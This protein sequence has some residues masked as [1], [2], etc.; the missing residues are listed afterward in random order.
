MNSIINR[1]E[2]KINSIKN[3]N[4]NRR[5]SL[6]LDFN[7]KI[8]N[9][10]DVKEV[11]SIFKMNKTIQKYV[12]EKLRLLNGNIQ[13]NRTSK[14]LLRNINN[15]KTK[16]NYSFN[17][18]IRNK[19]INENKNKKIKGRNYR[20]DHPLFSN[21]FKT[22]YVNVNYRFN[23]STTKI[24]NK[25]KIKGKENLKK[26]INEKINILIKNP[27]N[28]L[29]TK[30]KL[31]NDFYQN[32]LS[33]MSMSTGISLNHNNEIIYKEG[34]KDIIKDNNTINSKNN[35]EIDSIEED[36]IHEIIFKGINKGSPITFGNSFSYTNSKRSS[37]SN[38][39]E[40]EEV[41]EKIDKS[42]LLLKC[43]NETLKKELKESNQQISILKKEIERLIKKRK[44]NITSY[45]YNVDIKNKKQESKPK[46]FS[47]N[48]SYL[49]NICYDIDKS[50]YNNDIKIT[51]KFS[52]KSCYNKMKILN[53]NKMKMRYENKKE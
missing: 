20:H 11:P 51:K 21:E 46:I 23:D 9:I 2:K 19:S 27:D 4:Y 35:Y 25:S 26:K 44:M 45:K 49:D 52:N 33:S 12:N 32:Y 17:K 5:S 8:S 1:K 29:T 7:S 39:E 3:K 34:N 14:E 48:S 15:I 37:N 28:K 47:K 16:K 31:V 30:G 24:L 53:K 50:H 22:S 18:I 10:K 42:V 43:Q 40:K 41:Q 6:N 13:P 36:N 38:K